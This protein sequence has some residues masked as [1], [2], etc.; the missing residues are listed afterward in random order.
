MDEFIAHP[1]SFKL[2]KIKMNT[3]LVIKY[4]P[5]HANEL[6]FARRELDGTYLA[7]EEFDGGFQYWSCP[8]NADGTPDL[9]N[10]NTID[11]ECYQEVGF[12]EQLGWYIS[13]I[14]NKF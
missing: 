3:I 11:T 1:L 6:T 2:R 9:L 8:G 13:T 5:D 12:L 4:T 7:V 10:C 14:Y